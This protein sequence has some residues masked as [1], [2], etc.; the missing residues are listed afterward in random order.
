MFF[1]L[2]SV[3]FFVDLHLN[4]AANQT[5]PLRLFD[6][7]ANGK[8]SFLTQTPLMIPIEGKRSPHF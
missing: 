4:V 5:Y 1:I 8:Q 6:E 2:R 7:G 3:I